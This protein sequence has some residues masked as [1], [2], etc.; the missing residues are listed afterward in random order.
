MQ[1]RHN[2]EQQSRVWEA[3]TLPCRVQVVIKLAEADLSPE[4]LNMLRFGLAALC[5]AP[6]IVRGLRNR[7]IWK[8]SVEL[9]FWLFGEWQRHSKSFLWEGAWGKSGMCV[10]FNPCSDLNLGRLWV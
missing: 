2:A 9:G 4:L 5:F 3:L 10:E 6:S 7:K 8:P 1:E